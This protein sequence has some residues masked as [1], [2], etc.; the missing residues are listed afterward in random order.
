MVTVIVSLKFNILKK[1]GCFLLLGL[2]TAQ[3]VTYY[4]PML[5]ERDRLELCDPMDSESEKEE[6]KSEKE[7]DNK[8]R[9][10]PYLMKFV[11]AISSMNFL[12]P[13]D[14]Q[15]SSNPETTTPPPEPMLVS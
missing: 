5:A 3:S 14:L 9:M 11:A 8:L 13:I 12:P 6:T 10:D 4:W 1:I 15:S 7:K 2:F